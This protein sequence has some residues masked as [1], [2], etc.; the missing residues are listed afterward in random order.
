MQRLAQNPGIGHVR[1]DL[2]NEDVRFWPVFK[3]LVIY[4][5]ATRPLEIVRV[6]HGQRDV[7]HIL[8][9]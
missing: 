6:L 1:P 9:D 2:T 3:Y 4:R 5:P 7:K 8:G